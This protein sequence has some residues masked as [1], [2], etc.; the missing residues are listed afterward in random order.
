MATMLASEQMG[1][2]L[3]QDNIKILAV[4]DQASMPA[5]L[6]AG[7]IDGAIFDPGLSSQLGAKGFSIVA[8]LS[9]FNIPPVGIGPVVASA[10]LRRYPEV[11]EKVLTAL[12][13]S[14][15][16]SLSSKNK[17][18][19]LKTLMKH[20]RITD[21]AAAEE[22]YQEILLFNRKP[23]PSIKGMR[24]VQR[25]LALQNP[26]VGNVKIEEIVESRFVRKLDDSGFIDRLYI[27]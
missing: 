11:V 17:S 16:F 18:T 6:E 3:Q 14:L 5:A 12:V 10:Y 22:S 4:G 21:H 26:K 24:D 20:L 9:K 8:D 1:L 15:A 19:V 25:L 2:N 23:Y 27:N 13:E 7:A